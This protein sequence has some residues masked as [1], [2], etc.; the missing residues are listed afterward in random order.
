MYICCRVEI[1][2][3]F[4]VSWVEILSKVASNICPRFC[5][6]FFPEFYS[7][8]LGVHKTQIVCRGAKY[9]FGSL[10]GCQRRGFRKKCDFFVFVFFMLDEAKEK[11]WKNMDKENFKKKPR[12]TMFF[13]WL[14]RKKVF[15]VKMAILEKPAK[16]IC[17]QKAQKTRIFVATICFWKMVLF[18]C[19]FKITKHYKNRG[20]GRHKGKPKMA[21]NGTF[22]C[23]SAMLGRGLKGGFTICDTRQL[24]SAENTIFIVLSAKHSF[25]DMKECNLKRTNIYQK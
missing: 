21:Q 3:R 23:K 16:T 19:T 4:G 20:F 12:K 13:G 18:L 11:R 14:W 10:S 9:F 5:F 2:P 1:R 15:F 25:A 22:G 6:A 24:C 17:A 8:F 7:V